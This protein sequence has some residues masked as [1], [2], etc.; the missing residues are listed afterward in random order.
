MNDPEL[1]GHVPDPTFVDRP[2]RLSTSCLCGTLV[3][4]G[5]RETIA[6]AVRRHNATACH[7]DWWDR[8]KYDWQPWLRHAE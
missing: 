7:R 6:S 5:M 3:R 8:V 4:V 1:F 2:A